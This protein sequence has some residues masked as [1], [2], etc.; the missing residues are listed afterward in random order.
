MWVAAQSGG[1]LN[2]LDF[3]GSLGSTYYQNRAFLRNL[4]EVQWNIIEQP[5]HVNVGKKYF[6]DEVLKF[7][8]N[9][10]IC[11]SETKPNVILLSSVLQY[12]ENPYEILKELLDLPCDY[13]IID[14]T[15][16]WDGLTDRLCVQ[17][18]P[19]SIYP[20]SYPSWIFAKGKFLHHIAKKDY[21]VIVDF[22]NVDHLSGPVEFTYRGMI[23]SRE[24]NV[25]MIC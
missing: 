24:R 20:A 7:F 4:P 21:N 15:P 23:V 14:K 25:K 5:A 12:L 3:G 11:L 18:V 6:E 2:V 17:Q 8:P 9:I 13:L 16:F 19:P 1:R 22:K 10:E